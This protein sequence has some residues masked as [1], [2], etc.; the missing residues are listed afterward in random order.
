MI[1][2]NQK[3]QV[4]LNP[5]QQKAGPYRVCVFHKLKTQ[6]A[7]AV[8]SLISAFLCLHAHWKSSNNRIITALNTKNMYF[9]KHFP[10]TVTFWELCN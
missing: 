6:M 8:N 10:T 7:N 5:N 2:F 3:Q 4:R 9:S 1:V